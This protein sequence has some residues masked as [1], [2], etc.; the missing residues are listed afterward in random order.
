MDKVLSREQESVLGE[1]LESRYQEVMAQVETAIRAAHGR[2]YD[3]LIGRVR[4]A[5]DESVADALVELQLAELDHHLRELKD[6]ERARD[7]LQSGSYGRCE[8]CEEP[9][10]FPRLQAWPAARRCLACQDRYE[11]RFGAEA[12]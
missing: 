9:I 3:D 2:K 10:A 4:D 1:A 7:K 6:L 11:R 12:Q 5:G 8:D